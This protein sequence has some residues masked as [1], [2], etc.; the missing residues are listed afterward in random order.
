MRRQRVRPSPGP[1]V[2]RPLT[3]PEKVLSAFASDYW[4]GWKK[5]QIANILEGFTPQFDEQW[6]RVDLGGLEQRLRTVLDKTVEWH[7]KEYVDKLA[8]LL[9]PLTGVKLELEKLGEHKL[10]LM[11]RLFQA[12]VRDHL[13][14]VRGWASA[15]ASAAKVVERLEALDLPGRFAR[16]GELLGRL[17]ELAG[18]LAGLL[19]ELALQKGWRGPSE[20]LAEL[21]AEIRRLSADIRERAAEFRRT[22]GEMLS[23]FSSG[24]GR[25][26]ASLGRVFRDTFG[27]VLDTCRNQPWFRSLNRSVT[28]YLVSRMAA[29]R[30]ASNIV[31]P[32]CASTFRPLIK[33]FTV[34]IYTPSI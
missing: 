10:A 5:A 27:H 26:A 12:P 13:E 8:P 24:A 20:R 34:S 21:L 6:K 33:R 9:A 16:A 30:A 1:S 22:M 14:R 7:R 23:S 32:A 19:D 4:G 15:A 31:A 25:M 11:E 18:R 28:G 3:P 17:V 2:A 29:A